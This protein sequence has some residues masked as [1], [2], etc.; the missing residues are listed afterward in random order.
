MADLTFNE[1]M[2]ALMDA[3]RTKSGATG[4]LSIS[5]ATEAVNGITIGGGT[6]DSTVKFGYWNADGK[7]Q[8]V[9]LSGDNPVDSG[10]P[11]EVNAVMFDTGKDAPNYGGGSAIE[12]Y[13]CAS[14][15]PNVEAHTRYIMTLSGAADEKI[16]GVY[17]R[18][19]WQEEEPDEWTDTPL[20]VWSNESG[21]KIKEY[22]YTEFN[23][24]ITD[25]SG[26]TVYSSDEPYWS[27]V[28][29]YSS[30]IWWGDAEEADVTL[31]FSAIT[32][33]EVPA[34]TEGWTGY[35][36]TQNAETGAWSKSDNLT[37]GL[38][39]THLKPM[40][41]SIYSSD[42]TIRVREMYDGATYPITSNGLVFYAP[43]AADYVDQISGEAA[44]VTGGTFTSHNGL[45]CLKLDGA[46]YARWVD[47]VDVPA[48]TS[49]YSLILLVAPITL[50]GW[51]VFFS[52]GKAGDTQNSIRANSGNLQ[53]W[54]GTRIATE[55]WQTVALVRH[56]GTAKAYLN[57]LLN[58][59][60]SDSSVVNGEISSPADITV[61]A[62]YHGGDSASG[63]FAH[64][65]IY[66]RELSADEVAE[67]HATLMAD[68][69][70]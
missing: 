6:G 64:A 11:V 23:Y 41:G 42:T 46:E 43:L 58:G 66:N 55:I 29:D 28:T 10:E 8:E 39:V 63:Y 21:C 56:N 67:I 1:L 22:Y 57:G 59:T 37:E 69:E 40:I 31:N 14:Y 3:V 38:T 52:I 20:A 2:T 54:G 36:V 25:S 50:S 32:T 70:Q 68:V 15:T 4:K 49:D 26:K 7:F 35:K 44:A 16:N 51:N 12:F 19:K 30:I 65:A 62:E 33:D 17:V 45:N 60:S 34:T 48:G 18:T 47:S 53:A 27:R 61:G 5:A 24:Y 9:D 13:E